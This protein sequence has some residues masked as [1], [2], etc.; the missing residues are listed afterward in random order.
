MKLLHTADL[1]LGLQRSGIS[2][3]D[4]HIRVLNE[5]L[6]RAE[7]HEVDVLLFVGDIFHNRPERDVADI[8]ADFL[9]ML[10]PTLHRGTDVVLVS[11]NHDNRDLFRL[12]GTLLREVAGEDT[13]PLLVC[14]KPDVYDLLG[15]KALQVVAL[16]Y[17]PPNMLRSTEAFS[18]PVMEGSELHQ[19]LGATIDQGLRWLEGK[20]DPR[21]PAIF[22]GHILVTGSQAATGIE[23]DYVHDIAIAPQSL[24]H[25]TQYNALGH[26]HLCQKI[27]GASRPSWYA[28]APDRQD[29]GERAYTP[30]SLLVNLT[31]KPGEPCEPIELDIK[32]ATPFKKESLNGASGVA[33][34]LATEPPLETLG[35]VQITC[36]AGEFANLRHQILSVC[37]RLDVMSN[38]V[39][40]TYSIDIELPEDPY[41][42]Q[43]N[44]LA[45][46]E[47]KFTGEELKNLKEAFVELCGEVLP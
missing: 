3:W 30:R 42:V 18:G 46:L 1:H 12:M 2:R 41:D 19:T 23:L 20:V 43:A 5:I 40:S 22:A 36:S 45:Y 13:L 31:M 44:V 37:P 27:N 34:F 33:D 8:A 17:L 26:I 6:T 4:D 35:R 47:E 16:P 10:L 11:G 28:G 14:Y 38:P 32:S 7:E 29:M 15:H 24:P 39:D 9:R 21:R 25:Y